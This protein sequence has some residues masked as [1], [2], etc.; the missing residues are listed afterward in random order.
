ILSWNHG[1]E[2]LFGYTAREVG[3]QHISI[4]V[5]PE[6]G[7]EFDWTNARVVAGLPISPLET[8]R[9]ARGGRRVEVS[10]SISPV[11]SASGDLIGAAV[12]MRDITARLRAE[13]E[14]H[15]REELFRTAFEDAPFGMALTTREGRLL[16]ANTT[17]CRMLG[18]SEA[19]L[20][21]F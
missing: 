20:C 8:V 12:I 16:Q 9:L 21:G 3:G 11:H 4:V 6:L 17:L 7:D 5:P 13:R 18:Y 1:A 15:R 14:I 19:E 2:L 10:L